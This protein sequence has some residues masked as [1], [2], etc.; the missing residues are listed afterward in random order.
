MNH[1]RPFKKENFDRFFAPGAVIWSWREPPIPVISNN[2]K[3]PAIFTKEPAKNQ[4]LVLWPVL[5]LFPC[6]WEPAVI[7][8]NRCFA[9]FWDP[10]GKWI[11][12]YITWMITGWYLSRILR[13]TQHWLLRI[14]KGAVLRMTAGKH[15]K[16]GCS[17]NMKCPIKDLKWGCSGNEGPQ[18]RSPMGLF[19]EWGAPVQISNGA[20]LRMRGPSTDLQWGCS[21]NEGPQYRSPMG[22]FWEWGAPVQI[23]NG[24]V[25]RMRG[26]S[27]DLQWGCFENEG[28]QYRSPMALFW[29]LGPPARTSKGAGTGNE[30]PH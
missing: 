2:L 5:W 24:A 18:H 19:W 3:E 9:N 25:L 14:L 12:I 6:F 28:P 16:W 23:S 22:L 29:E 21:E 26:P 20:V 15:L 1:S 13:T 30:G 8:Q 11:Y 27:T 10:A 7:H 17:R 4:L